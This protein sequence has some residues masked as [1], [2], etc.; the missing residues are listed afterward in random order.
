MTNKN[1]WNDKPNPHLQFRFCENRKNLRERISVADAQLDNVFDD[2]QILETAR[3]KKIWLILSIEG[4][5]CSMKSTSNSTRSLCSLRLT[6]IMMQLAI[7][8]I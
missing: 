2:I 7:S 5:R 3:D 1:N 6:A 4:R 8:K